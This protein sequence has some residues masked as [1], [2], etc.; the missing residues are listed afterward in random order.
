MGFVMSLYRHFYSKSSQSK[1]AI[2]YYFQGQHRS[3]PSLTASTL[4]KVH[5][6]PIIPN[7]CCV[8][9]NPPP[10]PN[11]IS[12]ERDA[13]EVAFIA[14]RASYVQSAPARWLLAAVSP[15]DSRVRARALLLIFFPRRMND[16]PGTMPRRWMLPCWATC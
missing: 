14:R 6:T 15:A 3:L 7:P 11:C 12:T 8:R 13:L 10:P 16:T 4:L 1:I 5:F 9:T 2:L